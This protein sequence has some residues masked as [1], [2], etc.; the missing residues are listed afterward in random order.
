MQPDNE[1]F[2]FAASLADAAA[3]ISR[4]YFRQD[5]AIDL[6]SGNFPVTKVDLEIETALRQMIKDKYP[7]H[8]I[9][10]EEY[11]TEPGALGEYS[12]VIDPI[13]GTV[14]FTMGKPTFTTLIALTKNG[15]PALGIID[16]PISGERFIGISDVGAYTSLRAQSKSS[17]RALLCRA[18]QST[19]SSLRALAWQSTPSSLRATAWQSMLSHPI[20]SS[21]IT[22]LANARL[23]A[24]TPDMFTADELI[25]FNL[26]KSQVRICSWG[27]DAYAYAM[28]ASGHIDVI[29]ES[30]LQYYDVAAL[31]PIITAS[32]GIIT[33][34]DGELI[35]PEFNGQC[36]ASSNAKL[37][38]KAL[39]I[40]RM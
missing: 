6:K 3:A 11:A 36:L 35:T 33:T 17:L 7:M 38:A 31:M 22:D 20:N 29:M 19:S 40:I 32:G 2:I 15:K 25:K 23:N 18:W 5:I 24:T 21:K 12:W 13:D 1:L 4:R 8:T 28:L 39:E 37:H 16:Q 34:W 10:G 30:Q 9:I 26:L 27:G 14:A